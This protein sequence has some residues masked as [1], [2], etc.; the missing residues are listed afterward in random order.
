MTLLVLFA[1]SISA[2]SKVVWQGSMKFSSWSDV[3]NIDGNKLSGAKEDDVLHLSITASSGAQL[4]MSWGSGWTNFEDLGC[5][6]ISGDYEM[7]ITAKNASY[8]RQGIHIKGVNYT[9]TAVTLISNDGQY[10]TVSEDLFSWD[11][12]MLSGAT[13]GKTCTVGIK[14]YGGAGWYWPEYVDL[15]SYGSILINLL[16]PAAEAMTVQLFYGEKGVK[17][18][19][20]AKGDTQCRIS[21][22]SAH[23]KAYSLN[24]ISEKA[25]TI[26]LGNVNLTDKQG[27]VVAS[28][29]ENVVGD[30]RVLSTEYYNV[31]GLRLNGPQRGIN[32]IKMN[33]EG[34]R[35][36]VR[37]IIR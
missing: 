32:I 36:I 29:V 19:T 28:S 30:S 26:A 10:E 9:L 18:Q 13:Q 7:I 16:Q 34:G 27:N 17:S 5:K 20:V 6:D 8:L 1:E 2:A 35:S 3:L 12:L 22:T 15:S 21:L 25:Q 4:Q 31:S 37:K 23:K 11:G 14:A 24:I 33:L